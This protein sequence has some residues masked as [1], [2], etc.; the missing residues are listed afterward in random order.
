MQDAGTRPQA[1]LAG[2]IS[3]L[4]GGRRLL[5]GSL[6]RGRGSALDELLAVFLFMAMPLEMP[7]LSALRLP[8]AALVLLLAALYWRETVPLARRGWI[9]FLIPAFCLLSV[10][11]SSLPAA[12]IRFSAYMTI[13]LI[14]AIVMATRLSHRQVVVAVF[15]A[16]LVYAVAGLVVLERTFVGGMGGGWAILGVY[17]QKNVLSTHTITMMI[18]AAAILLDGRYRQVWRMLAVPGLCLGLFYIFNARS[19][20]GV[21]LTIGGLLT[22]ASLGGIWRPAASVKGLRPLIG[23]LAVFAACAAVMVFAMMARTDPWSLLLDLFGKEASLNGRTVIWAH[24]RELVA[25]NPL[26][27]VG[28]GA[29]WQPGVGAARQIAGMFSS[30]PDNM[31]NFHNAFFEI[32]VHIGLAGLAVYLVSVG[33]ALKTLVMDWWQ[34]QKAVDGFFIALMVVIITRSQT[35]SEAFHFMSLSMMVLW[36]GIFLAVRRAVTGTDD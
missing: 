28:A 3:A 8:L 1:G 10:A 30:D 29:F 36:T 5:N 34:R 13:P 14:A 21:L 27:G 6:E 25:Q 26:L 31:F 33:T 19:A 32:T 18:A 20:T 23:C 12:S 2:R 16:K 4:T 24:A 7:V 35:E 15:L 9:F 22:V 17:P 11:W